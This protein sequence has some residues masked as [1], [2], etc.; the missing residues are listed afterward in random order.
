MDVVSIEALNLGITIT[1]MT[2]NEAWPAGVEGRS[3]FI[4]NPAKILATRGNPIRPSHSSHASMVEQL[5][6]SSR[7][8]FHND[9]M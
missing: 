3:C 9:I 2:G 7:L 6:Y 8:Y 4:S 1:Q 5:H